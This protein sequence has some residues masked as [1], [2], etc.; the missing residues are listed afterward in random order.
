MGKRTKV[1]AIACVLVA[2]GASAAGAARSGFGKPLRA[3]GI[4][5]M[6]CSC[7]Q[8]SSSDA[9]VVM[10]TFEAEPKINKVVRDGPSY[11]KLKPGDQI[12]AIDGYLITT[13][14][15][16]RR[17]SSISPGEPVVLT[18]RRGSQTRDETI[19]PDLRGQETPL[20]VGLEGGE[21]G[22]EVRRLSESVEALSRLSEERA[23]ELEILQ[24]RL[25]GTREKLVIPLERLRRLEEHPLIRRGMLPPE[26][27]ELPELPQL[28]QLP[29][30][31]SVP[32]VENFMPQGSFGFALS[33]RGSI[34]T[35]KGHDPEWRFEEPPEIDTVEPGSP[36]DEA[37]LQPGDV[38]LR[39]D[40]VALD[41]EDGGRRF[42]DVRPGQSVEWTIRRDG[43][44]RTVEVEAVERAEGE[45]SRG[46]RYKGDLGDTHIEV[47]GDRR[48]RV[49]E[50]ENTITI[51]AGD[52][53]IRL[54][55][56]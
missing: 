18:L 33:F 5:S 51:H 31:P 6:S 46:V 30:L 2:L 45:A 29:E 36:A 55:R 15:G 16:G 56:R 4:K 25:D 41:T 13:V 35:G 54:K 11:G 39:I 37:G 8:V 50:D 44:E 40:G 28:P 22:E 48:V 43:E 47:E 3:L 49:I 21:R 34:K 53:T 9:D 10:W 38:L 26:L 52:A 17:F 27:P 24:R 19:T 7:S 14:E 1:I 23:S 12:V 32:R 20:I 42:S